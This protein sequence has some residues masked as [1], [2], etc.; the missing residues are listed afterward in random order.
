M[1][2]RRRKKML[3]W[4]VYKLNSNEILGHY[5]TLRE[6]FR[7]GWLHEHKTGEHYYIEDALHDEELSWRDVE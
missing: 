3:R 5:D 2:I 6:A 4:I 1:T 7:A